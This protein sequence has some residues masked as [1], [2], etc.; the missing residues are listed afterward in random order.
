MWQKRIDFA[1]LT[2]ITGVLAL[3][4]PDRVALVVWGW[5]LL[6]FLYAGAAVARRVRSLSDPS[7]SPFEEAMRVNPARPGRPADLERLERTIG[8]KVFEPREF[9]IQVRP[10]LR[11][12]I[13]H[14]R[15]RSSADLD[16]Y[17]ADLAGAR[18]AEDVFEGTIGISDIE[19]ALHKIEASP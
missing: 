19:S 17:L 14:R 8:V 16:P 13:E 7:G 3:T 10:L 1:L 4:F 18:P 9:D 12:L 5:A 11:A 2:I 15:A 6:S